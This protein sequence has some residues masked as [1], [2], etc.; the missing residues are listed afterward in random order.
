VLQSSSGQAWLAAAAPRE[1]AALLALLAASPAPEDHPARDAA[2]MR[3]LVRETR[4]R[5]HALRPG[6]APWPHTGSVALPI[7]VE[8]RLLGCI[9]AIWMARAVSVEE[10]LRQCLEPLRE[11]QARIVQGVAALPGGGRSASSSATAQSPAMARK[12]RPPTRPI[13]GQPLAHI[14]P[15]VL[16]RD[17]RGQQR[18][19]PAG[20]GGG[21]PHQ[22]AHG[23]QMH[24]AEGQ[25]MQQLDHHQHGRFHW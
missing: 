6:G 25:A 13:E 11:A 5:G 12:A 7:V 4:A 19:R 9:A 16:A 21:Q 24:G 3:R 14:S 1:R 2:L 18:L 15:P 8:G 10:G 22:R 23:G 20:E 17:R